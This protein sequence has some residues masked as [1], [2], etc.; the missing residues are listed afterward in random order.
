ML[1]LFMLVFVLAGLSSGCIEP[2]PQSFLEPNN[3]PRPDMGSDEGGEDSGV[4]PEPILPT[5]Q[6]QVRNQGE[7]DVDCGGSNCPSCGLGKSCLQDEDC[8]SS[9]CDNGVCVVQDECLVSDDVTP[10]MAYDFGCTTIEFPEGEFDLD[11]IIERGVELSGAGEDTKLG[12]VQLVGAPGDTEFLINNLSFVGLSNGAID[13][14]GGKLKVEDVDFI[15]NSIDGEGGAI[16]S[17]ATNSGG[18]EVV[19]CEFRGNSAQRGG[20]IYANHGFATSLVNI[21]GSKFSGNY[22]RGEN[23]AGGAVFLNLGRTNVSRS[24]FEF[25]RAENGEGSTVSGG[26]IHVVGQPAV[27]LQLRHT[28]FIDNEVNS[29]NHAE[30][31]A[32]SIR[33]ANLDSM[34]SHFQSN[35]ASGDSAE[36]GA[37]AA[38]A[39]KILV[40]STTF[41]SNTTSGAVGVSQGAGINAVGNGA[42]SLVILN[43]TFSGNSSDG[44]TPRGGAIRLL[45]QF[46]ESYS[47]TFTRNVGGPSVVVEIEGD[48]SDSLILTDNTIYGDTLGP[49]FPDA[50]QWSGTNIV[51]EERMSEGKFA[52]GDPALGGIEER[53]GKW[54]HIPTF[55][56]LA[57]TLAGACMGPNE[58]THLAI[59]QLG[60]VRPN[61]FCTIGAVQVFEVE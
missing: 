45:N 54:V 34:E 25:N 5:C 32:I 21:V 12:R 2:P 19:N 55:V 13:H 60:Q 20:A 7:T 56:S 9:R 61:G 24:L 23:A 47:N 36:G 50:L 57:H 35:R 31:G 26:A 22:V 44:N 29:E 14:R 39:S 43:S 59:D 51:R 58:T 28:R 41:R 42:E 30:G 48:V 33:N 8:I 17:S 27:S 4:L 11:F 18:L 6:D 1:R 49:E 10:L 15:E 16:Y 52:V 37:I 40:A 46:L 3:T 38:V 53:D